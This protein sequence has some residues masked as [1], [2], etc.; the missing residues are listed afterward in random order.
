[1]LSEEF[2]G[3]TYV[4]IPAPPIPARARETMSSFIFLAPPHNKYPV[5]KTVYAKSRQGFLPNISLNFPYKGLKRQVFQIKCILIF[6]T[7]PLL[8]ENLLE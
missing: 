1:M 4:D 2:R 7:E 8:T 6:L 5:P 3:N